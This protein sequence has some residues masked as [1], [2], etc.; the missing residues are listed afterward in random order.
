[1]LPYW[2]WPYGEYEF[3]SSTSIRM[4]QA[5]ALLENRKL[6]AFS[7]IACA[8]TFF[9][10]IVHQPDFQHEAD[11]DNCQEMRIISN[12]IVNNKYTPPLMGRLCKS[13][14]SSLSCVALE[15]FCESNCPPI[16]QHC[17]I[18]PFNVP[19]LIVGIQ[20]GLQHVL[21]LR[22]RPQL[23]AV[24]PWLHPSWRLRN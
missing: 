4:D 1:M 7:G 22:M 10:C 3:T 8:P 9:S 2:P 21:G 13:I 20:T 19:F 15:D 23:G 16:L 18:T 11:W 24:L 5:V 14:D 6:G 17:S 12:D